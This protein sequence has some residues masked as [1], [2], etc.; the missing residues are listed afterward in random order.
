MS[1]PRATR[2]ASRT[3]RGW[4]IL[5]CLSPILLNYASHRAPD[6][7]PLVGFWKLR[8][9][10]TPSSSRAHGGELSD[11]ESDLVGRQKTGCS[12]SPATTT[13]AAELIVPPAQE[14]QEFFAAAEAAHA[15]RF[16]SK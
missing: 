15:K 3:A 12:S 16:A 6:V 7:V 14:I 10:T 4:R 2:G 13:S 9:E 1:S 8:R 11:L 5:S